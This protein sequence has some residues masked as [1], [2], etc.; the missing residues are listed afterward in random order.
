ML[1]LNFLGV[2]VGG[3]IRGAADSTWT[4]TVPKANSILITS[5]PWFGS[6]SIYLLHQLNANDKY[7]SAVIE[8]DAS[9]ITN[10]SYSSSESGYIYTFTSLDL[11]YWVIY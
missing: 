6:V 4:L 2:S 8:Q 10:I 11:Y 7:C 1:F 9:K 5:R 3:V